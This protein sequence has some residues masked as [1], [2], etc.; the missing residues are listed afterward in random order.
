MELALLSV[1]ISFLLLWQ[2]SMTKEEKI[3]FSLK[4]TFS[5]KG[6]LRQELKA[7]TG[8]QEQRQRPWMSVLLLTGLVL[9][10]QLVGFPTQN[11]LPVEL[12][13]HGTL[14]H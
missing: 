8:K 6:K 11:H 2:N 1:P 9:M 10:A 7:G 4:L 5:H 13:A 14:C 12:L 3:Y